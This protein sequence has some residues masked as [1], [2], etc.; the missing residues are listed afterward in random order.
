M[1]EGLPALNF[2]E[3]RFKISR[4]SRG[5][6]IFDP[7]RRKAIRLSPEEWVRQHVL[8]FLA[9]RGYPMSL[10]AVEKKVQVGQLVQRADIV[11]YDRNAN[12]WLVVEC[13]APTVVLSEAVLFQAARYNMRLNAG[14]FM[15][16]NGLQHFYLEKSVRELK[17][18][19]QLP[20]YPHD[21]AGEIKFA[22]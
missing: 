21:P 19:A 13:K 4:D 7:V 6:L 15:L 9:E 22:R 14:F 11:V 3:Y 1:I 17:V 18:L 5:L 12:A 10:M 2:P 8:C 16:S 20:N